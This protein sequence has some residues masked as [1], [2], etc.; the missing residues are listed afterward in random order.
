MVCSSF[1]QVWELYKLQ[2]LEPFLMPMLV[3]HLKAVTRVQKLNHMLLI[4]KVNKQEQHQRIASGQADCFQQQHLHIA[5]G[6]ADCSGPRVI[7]CPR[8]S[9]GD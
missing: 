5:S 4:I 1:L 8:S 3:L 7:Q 9:I 2:I 6:Q